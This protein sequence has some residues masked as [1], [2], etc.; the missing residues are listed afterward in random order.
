MREILA[1]AGTFLLPVALSASVSTHIV[2]NEGQFSEEVLFSTF[3]GDVVVV[4]DGI[5]IGDVRITFPGVSGVSPR[6][7]TK[8]TFTYVGPTGKKVVAPSFKA[9]RWVS[10][11]RGVEV[12]LTGGEGGE[13]ELQWVIP[14]GVPPT[15][16]ALKVEG[17]DITV[18]DGKVLV[19]SRKV[20][21]VISHGYAFQGDRKYGVVPQVRGEYLTWEVEGYDPNY[22]LVI[23]P[24]LSAVSS[25]TFLGGSSS[26]GASDIAYANSSVY[27][28]GSTQ[29]SDFPASGLYSGSGDVFVARF[30]TTLSTLLAA[31]F[32]G[33]SDYD[34][35]KAISVSGN[36]VV[37]GGV[38]FSSDFPAS[39]GYFSTYSGNGD[40]FLVRR[41]STLSFGE[42]TFLG[43]SQYDA[44]EDVAV[45][46]SSLIYAVGRTSS[47]NMPM[48]GGYSSTFSGGSDAFLY[49]FSGDLAVAG[50]STFLGGS[51]DD[52]GLGMSL[53]STGVAVVGW[54]SSPDFPLASPY[55]G[56]LSGVRDAFVYV[57]SSD[58]YSLNYSTYVG[59]SDDDRAYALAESG[60]GEIVVVGWTK[61]S[62]FPTTPGAHDT[63]LDGLSDAFALSLSGSTLLY[64]TY[65][66]GGSSDAAE[67]VVISPSG[68]GFVVGHTQSP[69]FPVPSGYDTTFGGLVD[70]FVAEFSLSSG[71]LLSG[72]YLGGTNDDEIR[73]GALQ[74]STTLFVAGVSGSADFPTTPG[75]YDLSLTGSG[76]GTVSRFS[77][78]TPLSYTEGEGGAYVRMHDQ[79][80]EVWLDRPAYVGFTLYGINGR[81]LKRLSAGYLP[82]GTYTFGFGEVP[83][84]TY[85]LK[86]R[87][88]NSVR[89]HKVIT[90]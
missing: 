67:D 33:G 21:V 29:S 35:G 20:S 16:A 61:S 38:T 77:P 1:A 3:P 45:S 53:T 83:A 44:V 2:R 82:A 66:G 5:L 4:R 17:G 46:P 31:L 10:G 64:S 19:T 14:A 30:D 75:A 11:N 34:E 65:I 25:S 89:K 27:V 72:T 80:V 74:D 9:V 60:P 50:N 57:L 56:L 70:G 12:V 76:D 90:R 15:R 63:A 78:G 32:I 48:L 23:D 26:D 73:A 69:D 51:S 58:L 6:Y 62:D 40:G 49:S 55:D 39:S 59:G 52:W 18:R 87:V 71:S 88:G 68:R 41:D 37:V 13:L 47:P 22:S 86:L 24:V 36:T 8:A 7:R 43:G 42:A 54:T 84:G 28:V 79:E 85:I 81:V